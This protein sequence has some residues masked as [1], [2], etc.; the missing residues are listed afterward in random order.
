[1]LTGIT[2]RSIQC[3][4]IGLEGEQGSGNY[5][6]LNLYIFELFVAKLVCFMNLVGVNVDVCEGTDIQGQ[7][8]GEC[9]FLKHAEASEIRVTVLKRIKTCF[10]AEIQKL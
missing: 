9:R 10:A 7:R 1:M 8:F 6:F 5:T 3:T 4:R 2:K